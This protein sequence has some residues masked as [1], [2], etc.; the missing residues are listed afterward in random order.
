MLFRAAL[1][2]LI[3]ATIFELCRRQGTGVRTAAWLAL[4][5]FAVS[6]PALALRPQ[7]IGMALFALTLFLVVDRAA[8]PRRLWLVVPIAVLW[9]NVHGSF[10]LAPAV[11]GLAWIADLAERSPR[12]HLALAVAVV[13]AV[14]CC[15]T[16]F[17]PSVW[18]YAAQLGANPQVTSQ[19]SE[20]QPT[21]LRDV[22][23]ILFYGSA[24]LVAAYLA[25][26]GRPTPWPT[27]LWLGVFFVIGAYAARGIAWWPFAAVA[28]LAPLI[29]ADRPASEEL[30]RETP[31]PMRVLN[32]AV[33]ATIVVAC[34]ALLPVWRPTDP[35]LGVPQ[36]ILAQ[37][38]P[39]ITGAVREAAVPGD[40]VLVPQRWASWFEFALPDLPVAVDS[41]IELFPT[42]VWADYLAVTRGGDGWEDIL[43]AWS[44][45]L[46][47]ADDESFAARLAA[48]G[49]TAI[50][51]DA[52]GTVLLSPAP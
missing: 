10:F 22:S 26:R 43:A 44:P 20:W 51:A 32:A 49:W 15:L 38:P 45:A 24:L 33:A 12:R 17:G 1:V 3:A 40:R 19:I 6:A 37:A 39:G 46:V 28:A 52:D 48:V 30:E 4:G 27:L 41:R 29:G 18:V 23:G 13:T 25:R 35:D 21:S 7:L 16:P 5:A 50:H 34:V 14:A 8:H 47:V 31:R 42:E 2:G 36:G 11:L 9:A